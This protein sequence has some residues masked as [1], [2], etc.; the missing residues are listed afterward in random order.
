MQAAPQ[1]TPL[2]RDCV[3]RLVGR[4]RA[5]RRVVRL[6]VFGSR[7]RGRSNVAS[8]LDL[9]VYVS[10]ARDRDIE[11]W[12]EEQR[13]A[14]EAQTDGLRLQLIPFFAGEAPSALDAVVRHEGISLWKNN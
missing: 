9:A 10:A 14:V 13:Q 3:D 4:L 1:L 12:I 11:R 7:A 2:E 6:V 5:D 8:D